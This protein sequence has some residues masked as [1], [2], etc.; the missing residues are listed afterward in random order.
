MRASAGSRIRRAAP[1]LG[2]ATAPFGLLL[3][4]GGQDAAGGAV[5]VSGIAIAAAAALW[6]A[7]PGAAV[8]PDPNSAGISI[9]IEDWTE[10]GRALLELRRAGIPVAEHLAANPELVQ[11]LHATIR[12][13]GVNDATLELMGV[14]DRRVLL[15]PL[16]EVVPASAQT[17]PHWIAAMAR[18]DHLY[19]SESRIRRADGSQRDCLVTALLPREPEDWASIAVSVI[20]IS[21][22]KADQARLAQVER[23][24]ARATHAATVGVVTASIAHEVKNPLAA[25]VTNAEAALR[26][27][28]R[29]Q[30]DLAEAQAAI[31]AA[32][33]DALR[34]RDV[35]DR[36][37]LLL[38]N[39]PLAPV[40][41]DIAEAIRNSALLVDS[42]L[43][44]AGAVLVI[45]PEPDTPR[46]LADLS[47]LRQIVTNLL[48]NAAQ[49]MAGM[50]EPRDILVRA[51]RADGWVRIEI[52]DTGTGIAAERLGR[53]F[54]PFFTTKEAGI[55]V[56][57]AIC[58]A[59]V[60]AHG[61]R[62][63][64]S[65]AQGGGAVIHFTLPAAP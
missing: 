63:W 13:T 61:G 33:A 10:V 40:T 38:S 64:A 49:A 23:E 4:Q 28:R 11:R 57:L 36:T 58:R 16:R 32:V 20:D 34:A 62:I 55:G 46:V 39:A 44:A 56:G 59:C 41:L 53:I 25:V 8:Q 19:R 24:L 42:E 60:E 52:S 3:L 50:P 37:R 18:G 27:L 31:G 9:W 2:A 43:R 7:K 65:N 26:W 17:V 45:R 15:G 51:A 29:P 5:L 12:I 48:V 21:D 35:V 6:P 1:W 14:A 30:P 22:Y 54:E 47:R